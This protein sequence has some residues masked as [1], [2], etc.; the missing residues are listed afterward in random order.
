MSDSESPAKK[1]QHVASRNGYFVYD[2]SPAFWRI[3]DKGSDSSVS[4]WKKTKVLMD[5]QQHDF[6]ITPD[7]ALDLAEGK[8]IALKINNKDCFLFNAGVKADK[9]TDKN[10]APRTGYTIMPATAYPRN[11]SG[12]MCGYQLWQKTAEGKRCVN[13]RNHLGESTV[14]TAAVAFQLI[15]EGESEFAG[16]QLKLHGI[17]GKPYELK[18]GTKKTAYDARCFVVGEKNRHD[19]NESLGEAGEEPAAEE[20]KPRQRGPRV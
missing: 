7:D 12:K 14:I 13:V 8:D 3:Y 2:H 19:E 15:T 9:Y 5:G 11:I 16:K 4:C 6:E 10:G 17:V 1:A 20:E 18:D